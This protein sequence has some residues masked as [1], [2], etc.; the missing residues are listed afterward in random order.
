MDRVTLLLQGKGGRK[1]RSNGTE[2]TAVGDN[3]SREPAGGF[4]EPQVPCSVILHDANVCKVC[5]FVLST[6]SAR[7]HC[8]TCKCGSV[9][10]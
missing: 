2:T 6:E 7:Q 3:N 1:Q 4:T 10:A 8:V 9:Q 5:R